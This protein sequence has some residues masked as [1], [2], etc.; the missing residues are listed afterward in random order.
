MVPD[1]P[2]IPPMYPNHHTTQCTNLVA[3]LCSTPWAAGLNV[4]SSLHWG[5]AAVAVTVTCHSRFHFAGGQWTP[6][7]A[8][9]CVKSAQPAGTAAQG[10]ASA[11]P[12]LNAPP[13]ACTRLA[14]GGRRRGENVRFDKPALTPDLETCLQQV[15]PPPGQNLQ[16]RARPRTAPTDHLQAIYSYSEGRA[17][18][19]A[20]DSGHSVGQTAPGKQHNLLTATTRCLT[21]HRRHI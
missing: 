5:A 11:H 6:A 19:V 15:G 21:H 7:L 13:Q 18:P 9:D 10:C 2:Y 3:V 14:A 16:G 4:V 8:N 20:L 1:W 12:A 17:G